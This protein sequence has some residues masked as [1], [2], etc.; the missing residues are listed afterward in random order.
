MGALGQQGAALMQSAFGA[1]IGVLKETKLNKGRK[2]QNLA[3]VLRNIANSD[4]VL[5]QQCVQGWFDIA[6]SVKRRKVEK[7][8]KVEEVLRLVGGSTAVLLAEILQYW[9]MDWKDDKTKRELE[10]V[11]RERQEQAEKE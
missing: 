6:M 11:N 5:L 2:D 1:W 4:A 10:R 3:R 9:V 8:K 7:D